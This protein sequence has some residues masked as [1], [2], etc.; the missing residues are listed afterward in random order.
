MEA[1]CAYE[2]LVPTY[3]TTR[4]HV[5]EGY[6]LQIRAQF[7]QNYIKQMTRRRIAVFMH[8]Y[9]II[10]QTSVFNTA[11]ILDVFVDER[12]TQT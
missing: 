12:I 2:T 9:M 1:S 5:P 3:K 11:V 7:Q 10:T 6:N 4:R 8:W